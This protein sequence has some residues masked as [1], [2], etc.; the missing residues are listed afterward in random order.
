MEKYRKYIVGLIGLILLGL[1]VI[2]FSNIIIWILIAA[3][4]AMIGNP[5][6]ELIRKVRIGKIVTPKWAASLLTIASIYFIIIILIRLLVPL[7]I[8]QVEEF[9]AIDIE[10]ISEGL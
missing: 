5:L 1:F 10:T 8:D 4:V 9:Q 6:V 3:F 2:Y 7:V